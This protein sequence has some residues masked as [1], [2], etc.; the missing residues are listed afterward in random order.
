MKLRTSRFFAAGTAAVAL[1]AGLL[2]VQGGQT[3][4][5]APVTETKTIAQEC[6]E[7]RGTFSAGSDLT[8]SPDNV[9]V[10]YPQQVY[11]GETFTV[12][13][14][15]GQMATGDKDTGRMKYDVRLPEGVAISNLRISGAGVGF[16]NNPVVQRVNSSGAPDANGE[17]ARIWD[18][19]N[20]V[21]N[22]GNENDNW[23]LWIP[24]AGLQVDRH[25]T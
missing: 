8:L 25:K 15:P 22:G 14:Q 7:H 10:E 6:V 13:L 21:N 3:A 12:K 17:F 23:Q 2:T 5:A 4:L 9:T 24:R 19:G 16:N 18:G 1:V 11:P 20:S